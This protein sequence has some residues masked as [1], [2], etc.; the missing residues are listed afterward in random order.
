MFELLKLRKQQ[1]YQAIPDIRMARMHPQFRGFPVLSSAPCVD[2]CDAC[3]AVCPTAAIQLHPLQLDLGKCTLCGDCQ[4]VCPAERIVFSNIN[5][6]AATSRETL[7][8]LPGMSAEEYQRTAVVASAEIKR[9]FGRS[10][11]LR[12]VSAGGCNGCGMELGACGNVNFDMGRFGI[13][14][15]ASP[16]HADGLVI[17]GALSKNMA[18]ALMAAYQSMSAPKIVIVIGAC[19]IS[20]GVFALS[21]ELN[22]SFFDTIPVDLYIPGCPTHPLT[23]ING[24][25]DFLGKPKQVVRLCSD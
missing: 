11:K 19:A 22:R 17:S 2:G 6:L 8:I 9:I 12:H 14:L 18:D 3:R 1:G 5:R 15:V 7:K 24:I 13:E 23:F 20:G 4:R 16:R 10:L 21:Q 25:L